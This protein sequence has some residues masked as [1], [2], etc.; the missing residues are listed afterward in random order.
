[1]L[2]RTGR[3]TGLTSRTV[4]EVLH[5]NTRDRSGCSF[6]NQAPVPRGPTPF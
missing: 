2:I 4:L 5:D 3:R 1:M 6:D